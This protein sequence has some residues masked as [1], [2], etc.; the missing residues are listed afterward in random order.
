MKAH[1]KNH[2]YTNGQ[3]RLSDAAKAILRY[4]SL[5]KITSLEDIPLKDFQPLNSGHVYVNNPSNDHDA[6]QISYMGQNRCGA[7]LDVRIFE[8]DRAIEFFA[9]VNFTLPEYF[10]GVD[11]NHNVM[12]DNYGNILTQ[13]KRIIAPPKP[14]YLP[15]QIIRTELGSMVGKR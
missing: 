9:R 15:V 3:A 12:R 2:P 13:K 8:K 1:T 7:V 10:P 4:I 11:E 14:F 5:R 6:K